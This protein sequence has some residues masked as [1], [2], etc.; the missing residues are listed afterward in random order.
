MLLQ[1]KQAKFKHCPLLT[2]KEDKYRFC[3]GSMC[4][5]WRYKNPEKTG[6]GDLGYCGLSGRPAGAM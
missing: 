4:M 6:E 3:L 5:M 2:T 1:E